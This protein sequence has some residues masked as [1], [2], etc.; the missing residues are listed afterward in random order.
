MYAAHDPGYNSIFITEEKLQEARD[1]AK[2]LEKF[3]TKQP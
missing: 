3:L 2:N 1:F